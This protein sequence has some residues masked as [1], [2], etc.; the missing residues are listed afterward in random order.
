MNRNI[1]AWLFAAFSCLPIFAQSAATAIDPCPRDPS[2]F[3]RVSELADRGSAAAQ[4]TMFDCYEQGRNV[5]ADGKEAIHWL[6]LSAQQGFVSAEYEL[7]RTYLYGRGIPADYNQAIV[8]EK[9]AAEAG[10]VDAQTDLALIYE[11]GFGVSPDPQQ[12]A[13]WNR[14]AAEQGSASAQLHLADALR[15]GRG[16]ERNSDEAL[17]WYLR[18][19][20]HGLPEA[21]L[22][23][24]ELYEER[25][26]KGCRSAIEW[27]QKAARSGL[28]QAMYRLGQIYQRGSCGRVNLES[29][30]TWFQI[31]A[32]HGSQDSRAAAA[33]LESKLSSTQ[34]LRASQAAERWLNQT[35]P[36]VKDEDEESEKH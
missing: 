19:A 29:A 27:Y 10:H 2:T 14:K 6:T 31:G 36:S 9:K 34:K 13:F 15:D 35:S 11:R 32:K 17:K 1:L 20:G 33:A 22:R 23:V 8:W 25:Q 26:P 24:A 12:A 28:A 21:E 16:V 7:G 18:A 4:A 30:L 3:A 5:S